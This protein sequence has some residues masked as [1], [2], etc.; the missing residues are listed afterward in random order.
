MPDFPINPISMDGYLQS[1]SASAIRDLMSEADSEGKF[2]QFLPGNFVPVTPAASSASGSS[3][4][5][6]PSKDVDPD[7]PGSPF[8]P[9]AELPSSGT[10]AKSAAG[11][12][13]FADRYIPGDEV[14]TDVWTPYS[15][16]QNLTVQH[17]APGTPAAVLQA[18]AAAQGRSPATLSAAA[19]ATTDA[20]NVTAGPAASDD[21]AGTAPAVQLPVAVES[22]EL[23]QV[24]ISDFKKEPDHIIQMQ[25][26]PEAEATSVLQRIIDGREVV[27]QAVTTDANTFL[28]PL[29]AMLQPMADLKDVL[30]LQSARGDAIP[31]LKFDVPH[32]QQILSRLLSTSLGFSSGQITLI[33]DMQGLENTA[34]QL[35]FVIQAQME[36][37]AAITA[38][39]NE[40][41]A[42]PAG[43]PLENLALNL[44]LCRQLASLM[45]GN[46]AIHS[47]VDGNTLFYL[48]LPA[49]QG[50]ANG[51]SFTGEI[52][53]FSGRR[54]LLAMPNSPEFHQT[55]ELLHKR[56]ILPDAA[57]TPEDAIRRF[58]ECR[59][60]YYD[61]ILSSFGEETLRQL[62][63]VNRPDAPRIPILALLFN[64]TGSAL[65]SAFESGCSACLPMPFTGSELFDT[66]GLLML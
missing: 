20:A 30:I 63:Q 58:S 61:A 4:S 59:S 14:P 12:F 8:P 51:K 15:P 46:L 13:S 11:S 44:T 6:V 10:D 27:S 18:Y 48:D 1:L 24:L 3:A 22:S 49:R 54:I 52:G 66:L 47:N 65:R 53:R 39:L 37:P 34:V 40:N 2:I 31:L 25:T 64:S 33:T 55:L 9:E 42:L 41:G 50:N 16:A 60:G 5:G 29:K 17:P 21:Q 7:V 32:T 23:F 36:L 19:A 26:D 45:Q 35:R 43:P 62:R 28:S 57:E 56:E 38:Y